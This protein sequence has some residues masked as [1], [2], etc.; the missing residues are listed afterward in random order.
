MSENL[1]EQLGGADA[2]AA[3]VATMYSSVA[4]DEDLA[5]FFASAD[6]QHLRT[7]QFEFI[8][9]ALGGPVSYSGAE[10]QSI[11]AGRGITGAHFSKFVGHLAD[12]MQQHGATQAQID[13]M[14]GKIALYRDRITGSA[15]I[16]G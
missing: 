6:M 12:A 1:F 5:H 10:L 15:N 4:A 2:I 7:M 9:S 3:I 13:S 16:D 8:A 14:L 11:H